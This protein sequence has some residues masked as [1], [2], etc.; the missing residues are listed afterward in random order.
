MCNAYLYI[1]A[2]RNWSDGANPGIFHCNELANAA[3]SLHD[4][5]GNI[6]VDAGAGKEST[7]SLNEHVP[8]N[9]KTTESGSGQSE[10]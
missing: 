9:V 5:G 4:Q 6:A 1:N 10:Q 8:A 7:K 2:L 3:W